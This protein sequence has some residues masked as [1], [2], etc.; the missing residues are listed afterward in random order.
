MLDD[1]RWRKE[2]LREVL[3]VLDELLAD[4]LFI[5]S[6]ENNQQRNRAACRSFPQ[7]M[8]GAVSFY[9]LLQRHEDE[10]AQGDFVF[11]YLCKPRSSDSWAKSQQFL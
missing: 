8:A 1:L 7:V 3:T 9:L 6:K 4:T 5:I 10:S 2:S 11:F